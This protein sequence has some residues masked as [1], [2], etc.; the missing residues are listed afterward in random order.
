MAICQGHSPSR[1]LTPAATPGQPGQ[2]WQVRR[3]GSRPPPGKR[4]PRRHPMWNQ[5]A[6]VFSPARSAC[7]APISGLC[8][9]P[10][11]VPRPPLPRR[12][13]R[14]LIRTGRLISF[15]GPRRRR[16]FRRPPPPGTGR[17]FPGRRTRRR[18]SGGTAIRHAARYGRHRRRYGR[19]R[20]SPG[21]N[22]PPTLT[23]NRSGTSTSRPS[24]FLPDPRNPPP[25]PS[26]PRARRPPPCRPPPCRPNPP[27]RHRSRRHRSRRPPHLPPPALF[28]H[29]P[30][31]PRQRRS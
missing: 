3:A 5:P 13:R 17:Q 6:R 18:A 16:G 28:P 8:V 2:A 9:I 24:Q 20:E 1:F 12:I 14:T 19:T 30:L 21:N 31:P 22:P 4:P 29:R 23:Q 15:H 26:R 25:S 27:R 11:P 10:A 7:P